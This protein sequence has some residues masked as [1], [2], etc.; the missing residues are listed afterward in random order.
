MGVDSPFL[1][2]EGILLSFLVGQSA[3]K[4][5]LKKLCFGQKTKVSQNPQKQGDSVGT[6]DEK[7]DFLARGQKKVE[8]WV[9]R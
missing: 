5:V 7:R 1:D 3:Q 8:T 9:A 6:K 2:D 4:K